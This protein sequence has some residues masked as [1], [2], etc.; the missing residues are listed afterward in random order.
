MTLGSRIFNLRSNKNMKQSELARELGVSRQ[1]VSKWENDLSSPDVKNLIAL[2]ELFD[3][4]IEYLA[5]GKIPA[6]V[7]IPEPKTEV[8]FVRIHESPAI[9]AQ[10]PTPLPTQPAQKNHPVCARRPSPLFPA[11]LVKRLAWGY[12]ALSFFAMIIFYFL[13]HIVVR[14]AVAAIGSFSFLHFL[15]LFI[16]YTSRKT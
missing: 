7:E 11:L 2:A 15:I 13:Q 1:A 14:Y 10:A 5:Y 4:T 16:L 6:P 12:L 3:V 8:L 9:S